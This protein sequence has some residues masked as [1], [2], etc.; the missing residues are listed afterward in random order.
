MPG[1]ATYQAVLLAGGEDK[2]LH[3]LTGPAGAVKALLPVANK[4]LISYPLK[5]LSEAGLKHV[6][7]VRRS[8][9][10]EQIA[11]SAVSS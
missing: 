7:I 1:L 11:C 9:G 6:F 4:P 10:R 3:P 2:R 8:L 5:A